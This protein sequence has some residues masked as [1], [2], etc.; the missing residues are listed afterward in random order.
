MY[1][2]STS[3]AQQLAADR[4][5]SYEGV[6]T[7][8]RLRKL[9]R[10]GG[11]VA[12]DEIPR[13]P[14][15][16]VFRCSPHCI[17]AGRRRREACIVQGGMTRR[18][19]ERMSLSATRVSSPAFIGPSSRCAASNSHWPAATGEASAVVVGGEAGVGKTRLVREVADRAAAETRALYGSCIDLGEGGP[20]FGPMVEVLRTL[21]RG[22]GRPRCGRTR[23]RPRRSW[24]AS[25][26]SSR[27]RIRT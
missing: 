6:A 26:P 20:P 8:R 5:A 22:T 7:R 1:A 14:P 10:R 12:N 25:P 3:T 2:T 13:A 17:D 23:A 4:H 11:D 27:R 24:A 9:A 16:G 18:G 21:V 15:D 19:S